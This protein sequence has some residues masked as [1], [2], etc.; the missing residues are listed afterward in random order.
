MWEIRKHKLYDSDSGPGQQLHSQSSLG[1]L[2]VV[3]GQR[4]AK[5][6]QNGKLGHS[7]VR[8]MKG[9]LYESWVRDHDVHLGLN[10]SRSV[11]N[12]GRMSMAVTPWQQ[13]GIIIIIVH[14]DSLNLSPDSVTRRRSTTPNA[15]S[16]ASRSMHWPSPSPSPT[17]PSP[18]SSV[19][20]LGSQ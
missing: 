20:C 4:N 17:A 7:C 16:V 6:S 18:T 13:L 5:F 11:H 1:D 2:A 15:Q 9:R 8:V 12:C 3:E 14:Q 10:V 19:P